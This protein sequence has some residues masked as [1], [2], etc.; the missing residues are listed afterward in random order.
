LN[1]SFLLELMAKC[2]QGAGATIWQQVTDTLRSELGVDVAPTMDHWT[3]T[4][5]RYLEEVAGT[6]RLRDAAIRWLQQNSKK[7]LGMSPDDWFR[8]RTEVWGY[9]EG[10]LLRGK[11]ALPTQFQLN[12]AAFLGVSR[13]WQEKYA[14]TH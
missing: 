9:I 1:A 2:I 12:E 5:Q 8:R 4:I 13:A 11:L 14:E 10:G 6:P 3:L 7:P